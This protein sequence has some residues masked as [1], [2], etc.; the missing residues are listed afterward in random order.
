LEILSWETFENYLHLSRPTVLNMGGNQGVQLGFNPTIKTLF[1]R[2]PIDT[3]SSVPPS[4]YSELKVE[5]FKNDLGN[6]L[7]IST[8]AEHL[9]REFH[10]FAGIVTEDFELPG[11]T[12]IGAFESAIHRWLELI[13]R[14]E[15]LSEEK[16][17]GLQG[18]LTVLRAL[19][20]IHGAQA[21]RA[22]TGRNPLL[23]ERHDFRLGSVD[24]EVKSTR[25]TRRQH[26]IHGLEQLQ[27]SRGHILYLLSLRFE[28]AGLAGGK[29]LHDEIEEIRLSLRDNSIERSEFENRLLS[30]GYM[31]KDAEHY[32]DKLIFADDPVLAMV[33]K[34]L[35][36]ITKNILE[37]SLPSETAGRIGDVSYRI[38]IDGMGARQGSEQFSRVLGK[39]K[40]EV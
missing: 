20:K 23:A 22:W 2:I 21:V 30:S 31:D 17:L 27:P 7:E 33:D 28:S 10:R 25:S 26:I 24:I 39:L 35:P 6:F 11:Q 18:E 3:N 14:I 16:Q 8:K 9:F 15:L 12:A 13:S 37:A 29:S 19:I 38:D 32:H 34:H 5:I 4:P 36:K 40:M 1:L